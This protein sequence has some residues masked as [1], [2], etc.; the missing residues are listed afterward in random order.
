MSEYAHNGRRSKLLPESAAFECRVMYGAC[1][2]L[3]LLRAVVNRAM[4][5]RRSKAGPHE[6]IFS[7]ANNAASVMVTSSFMG[8]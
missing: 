2:A 5:W 3:F 7:E 4:P 6:S 1:Y 8:L